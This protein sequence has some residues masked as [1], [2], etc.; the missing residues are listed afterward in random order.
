MESPRKKVVASAVPDASRAGEKIPAVV[1]VA[2]MPLRVTFGVVVGVP[3]MTTGAVAVTL[4]TVPDPPP[5]DVVTERSIV[6]VMPRPEVS[7]IGGLDDWI[8][9]VVM[10]ERPILY[11]EKAGAEGNIVGAV[12][13]LHRPPVGARGERGE[14]FA[15][16]Y[17]ELAERSVCLGH[18]ERLERRVRGRC[19]SH[20]SSDRDVRDVY[21][22]TGGCEGC[23]EV[24]GPCGVLTNRPVDLRSGI[25]EL[26][27]CAHRSGPFVLVFIDARP[28]PS[29]APMTPSHKA[30]V[31]WSMMP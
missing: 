10:S 21:R 4:V 30:A 11:D 31:R 8:V 27:L 16:A 12:V 15:D 2:L 22:S 26:Y 9:T 6:I 1:C 18:N 7:V 23:G 25:V 19:G 13:P 29:S 24:I 28:M 5:L 17:V 20:F 3:V 14:G